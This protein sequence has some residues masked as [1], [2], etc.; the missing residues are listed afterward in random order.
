MSPGKKILRIAGSPGRFVKTQMREGSLNSSIF[1]LV[2]CCLGSGTLTV[3]Y[4]FYQNGF[5]IG[6][7]CILFGA[8]LS[9]FTGYLIA[10]ASEKTGGSCFEEI[11][12]ATYGPG[13]QKFTSICMIPTNMGFV[14][15]YIVLVSFILIYKLMNLSF[16]YSLNHLLHSPW[17]CLVQNS[18]VGVPIHLLVKFSGPVSL[19]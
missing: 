9:C 2:T 5:V 6:T 12:L 10:Y 14:I 4:A 18:P 19:L 13:W 16:I 8:V 17:S 7:A 1:N 15:T 11:A 3:P